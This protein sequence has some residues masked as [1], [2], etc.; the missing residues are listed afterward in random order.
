MSWFA[1]V[2]AWWSGRG[3]GVAIRT[4]GGD[5]GVV[6]LPGQGTQWL[7]TVTRSR[8]AVAALCARIEQRWSPDLDTLRA[9]QL[10]FDELLTNV[11][12]Y[13]EGGDDEPMAVH[14][15]HEDDGWSATIRYRAQAYD[16]TARAA[17]DTELGI[18]ERAVGGLGV[19][20]VRTLMDEFSHRYDHG[21]N[22]LMLRKRRAARD[23]MHESD[24][25]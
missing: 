12:D 7:Y 21:Y 8:A 2:R 23:P 13:A 4:H 14:V 25:I 18:A 10:A 9:F 22:V 3:D 24:S 16:P 6:E 19:H 20:L 15:R 11:I 1:R 17:P 5:D